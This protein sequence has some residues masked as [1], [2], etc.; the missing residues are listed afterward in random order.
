MKIRITTG[1]YNTADYAVIR[2]FKTEKPAL[3]FL[4]KIGYPFDEL[5]NMNWS[6]SGTAY[7]LLMQR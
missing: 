7:K 6:N 1:T 4:K 3:K 2:E 5:L